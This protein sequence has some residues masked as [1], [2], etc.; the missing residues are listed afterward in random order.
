MK[1][2][3]AFF[4]SWKGPAVVGAAIGITA[5]LLQKMGNPANMGLGISMMERDIVGAVGLHREALAQ[6]IRPEI[7]G[8]GLGALVA[9]LIFREFRVRGGSSTLVRFIMGYFAMVGALVFLGGPWRA[10]LRLA[11]GDWSSLVGLVGLLAGVGIGAL[12]LKAGFTMGPQQPMF[13]PAGIIFSVFMLMLLSLALLRPQFSSGAIFES[14]QGPGAQHAPLIISLAAGLVIGF[15]DQRSR[16]CSIR[17]L[18][19]LFL[20]KGLGP[21]AA[22]IALTAAALLANLALGQFRPGLHGQPMAHGVY[23]WSFLGMVLCGLT[24]TM[25]GGDPARHLVLAGEGDMDAS[26]FVFGMLAGAAFAHNLGMAAT[27]H[28]PGPWAPRMVV[29]GLIVCIGFGLVMREKNLAR[30]K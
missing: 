23:L 22:L 4:S 26:A 2:S 5:S 19:D 18:C 11:G 1:N 25:V 27:P 6:Y 16:F 10:L 15:L 14:S 13:R 29:F 3:G 7:I 30:L 12:F 17:A 21:L 20:R 24:F 9:S 8:L 28:G